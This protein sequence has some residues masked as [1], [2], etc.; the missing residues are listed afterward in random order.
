MGGR[1]SAKTL[2]GSDYVVTTRPRDARGATVPAWVGKRPKKLTATLQFMFRDC[3]A[4]SFKYKC[5]VGR[6]A[7]GTVRLVRYKRNDKYYA[8][9][10]IRRSYICHRKSAERVGRELKYL[11]LCSEKGCKFVAHLFHAFQDDR[12]VYFLLEYG[13]G[14]ELL[15]RLERCRR[16]PAGHV[17][18]YV[19]EVLCA[20]SFLHKQGIAYRDLKPDNIVID[21]TGHILLVDFG[22]ARPVNMA[23][24]VV[25]A[26]QGG[27]CAYRAPEITRGHNEPHG[28]AVD[29]WALGIITFEL[30]AGYPPFGNKSKFPKYEVYQRIN[31]GKIQFPRSVPKGGARDLIRGLLCLDQLKRLNYDGVR[32]SEWLQAVD[33]TAAESRD[34]EPP[35]VPESS[36]EEGDHSLFQKWKEPRYPNEKRLTSEQMAYSS[37]VAR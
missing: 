25:G 8:M 17:Q 19:S 30:L 13:V 16:L 4:R 18:F 27:T 20:L 1:F 34:L 22:L 37:I 35:W 23:G 9:K 6:G 24:L 21:A 36:A 31:R 10:C 28:I 5:I 2:P 14:G 32:R 26:T 12:H 15:G 29:F 3:T 7:A 33:W 11:Q